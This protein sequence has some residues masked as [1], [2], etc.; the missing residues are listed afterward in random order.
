M[1]QARSFDAEGKIY[2]LIYR[3]H[4]CIVEPGRREAL[5]ELFTAARSHNKQAGI[6]GA[7][8]VLDDIFVQTL[9]GDEQEVQSLLDRIRAD[10]RHDGLEVLETTLANGRVFARWSMAK[11]APE[12]DEPD[13]NLIAHVNGIAAAAPRGDTTAEQE[14]VLAVM[15]DA[16]RGRALA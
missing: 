7:L 11:V 5:G 1:S 15:R 4:S 10:R 6:S 16:A 14:A 12:G 13:I 3:S 9:E 2:R 8:L